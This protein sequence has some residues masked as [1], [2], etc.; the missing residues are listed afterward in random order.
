MSLRIFL[1]VLSVVVI[2]ILPVAVLFCVVSV[3][4]DGAVMMLLLLFV[5]FVFVVVVV[6]CIGCGCCSRGFSFFQGLLCF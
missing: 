3:F 6:E 2:F 5:R 4:F 1:I